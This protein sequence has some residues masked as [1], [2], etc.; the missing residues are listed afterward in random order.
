MGLPRNNDLQDRGNASCTP[1]HRGLISA[2]HSKYYCTRRYLTG[3]R[4][5]RSLHCWLMREREHY[6]RMKGS[7]VVLRYGSCSRRAPASSSRYLTA[8]P[9]SRR[10]ANEASCSQSHCLSPALEG[11][12]QSGR[13]V[14][15]ARQQ[16][17]PVDR[18]ARH[19]DCGNRP[20]FFGCTSAVKAGRIHATFV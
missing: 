7:V 13:S 2:R 14:R 19:H 12:I 10:T 8:V 18:R 4:V 9:R 16:Q 11:V 20:G 1:F 5:S 3:E 6:Y 15:S 17:P